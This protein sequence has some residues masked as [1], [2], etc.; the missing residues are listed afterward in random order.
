MSVWL[1]ACII[2]VT[3]IALTGSATVTAFLGGR[4]LPDAVV[5]AQALSIGVDPA[6]WSNGFGKSLLH[7][8]SLVPS[9]LY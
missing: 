2:P 9:P 7:N 8:P 4:Q 6:Y 1:I 5:A 3:Y